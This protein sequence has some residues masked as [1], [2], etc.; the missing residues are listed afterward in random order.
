MNN[1][2]SP[3][4]RSAWTARSTL[5]LF[6][7]LALTAQLPVVVDIYSNVV[8]RLLF[9]PAYLV[10]LLVYEGLGIEHIIYAFDGVFPGE[11]TALWEVGQI[12]TYYLFAVS[13]TW[14]GRWLETHKQKP[15]H[16]TSSN[17]GG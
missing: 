13:A 2:T 6:G 3:A 17:K 15:N 9:I 4:T 11:Q 14:L 10:S 7:F 12:V 5:V 1:H 8:F 16:Q